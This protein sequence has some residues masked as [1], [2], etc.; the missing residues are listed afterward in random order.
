MY[1]VIT[2]SLS[3]RGGGEGVSSQRRRADLSCSCPLSG[4]AEEAGNWN[5]ASQ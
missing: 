5:C 3:P 1:T 4:S 2:Y